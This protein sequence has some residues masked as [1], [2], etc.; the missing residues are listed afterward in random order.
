MALIVATAEA[1]AEAAK[2]V[3]KVLVTAEEMEAAK[4]V[5]ATEAMAE[6]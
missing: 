3:E 5:E 6:A 4:A 2:A 1:M